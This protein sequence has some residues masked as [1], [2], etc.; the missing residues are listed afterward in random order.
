M[1]INISHGNGGTETSEL[2]DNIFM[3]YFI[4]PIN[5]DMGDAAILNL[6]GPLAFTTD[7]FVVKPIF[8]PGGDI[9]RLAVC[10][11][12]NDI[13]TTGGEPK[14][15]SASFIIEEGFDTDELH[16]ISRSMLGAAKEANISIVTGDTKVIE[17][18]GGIYINTSGIGTIKN[19]L[20]GF[21]EAKEGD[22]II[23]T[24]TLGDHH[25][26]ILSQRMGICN[27]ITSDTAPLNN[28]VSS[29]V[30]K[31][32]RLHG[33]RD[34]TRG[35]LAT[36]L[37]EISRSS[38]LQIEIDETSIPVSRE[39]SGLCKILGLEPLYMGNEGKMLIIIPQEEAESALNAIKK[40]KYGANAE[41]V[42]RL[43]KGS[44]VIL[45]T[46]LGGQRILNSLTGEGLPRIC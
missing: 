13:L 28:I 2:I 24:G 1:K 22:V 18:N 32:V 36:V 37:N 15:L 5:Q 3:K 29:L 20:P 23:V 46:K 10:G 16:L 39:V 42:G 17:G 34:I 31:N 4:N 27:G 14:Y 41:V 40:E 7:S 21:K 8:F 33:M 44:G 11:T 43:K 30:K 25:A 9:G 26:C 45:N 19:K 6:Q 12:V 35:G 38:A